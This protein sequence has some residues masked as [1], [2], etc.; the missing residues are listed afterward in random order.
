M[1]IKRSQSFT[2]SMI[3]L[4]FAK[5]LVMYA[6]IFLLFFLDSGFYPVMKMS[7][8]TIIIINIAAIIGLII[9]SGLVLKIKKRVFLFY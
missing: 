5:A 6:S 9:T 3:M 8:T 2:P 7:G 4:T 1:F